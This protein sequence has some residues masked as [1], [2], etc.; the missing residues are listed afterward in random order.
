MSFDPTA[1]RF[2]RLVKQGRNVL[3]TGQAGTGCEAAAEGREA[4]SVPSAA[5][6][7]RAAY[8]YACLISIKRAHNFGLWKGLKASLVISMYAIL[9]SASVGSRSSFIR[10]RT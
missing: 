9:I 6:F 5:G 8:R 2:H 1:E 7:I 3:L 10:L 4:S